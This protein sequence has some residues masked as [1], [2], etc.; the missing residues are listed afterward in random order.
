MDSNEKNTDGNK[1]DEVFDRGE[2]MIWLA[3]SYLGAQ[4]YKP[5]RCDE[6]YAPFQQQERERTNLDQSCHQ[7]GNVTA[8][9]ARH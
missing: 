7:R 8:F 4:G 9:G 1:A 5:R 6:F 3:P 2:S